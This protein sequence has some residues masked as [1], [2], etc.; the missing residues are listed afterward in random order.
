LTGV[1]LWVKKIPF[2]PSATGGSFSHCYKVKSTDGKEAF[3]KA[4]DYSRALRSGD[5]AAELQKLT[6]AYIFERDILEL[7]NNKGLDRVVRAIKSG[8]VT[9]S[10]GGS[11][12]VVQ[13]LIFE[14]ADCD[15]RSQLADATK[16]NLSWK[17]KCLHNIA[18]GLGQLHSIE[19][20]HQDVKP[21]NV[22]VFDNKISKIAD[23]GRAAHKRIVAPHDHY[24][25]AGDPSY[26]P[27]EGL[28][29]FIQ[30]DWIY[31]RMGCDCYL[32]GSMVTFF[33]TGFSATAL[34]LKNLDKQH[35]WLNWNGTFDQ[36]LPFLRESYRLVILECEASIP[37]EKLRIE[38]IKLIKEL[39]EPD[40]RIRGDK[41]QR[42]K[43]GSPFA[44]ERYI[45]RF[46]TLAYQSEAG[47]FA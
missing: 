13:Y 8:N 32:L 45:S 4:L 3:L 11:S 17:L 19:I 41:S 5:P 27:P 18:T 24:S 38:I 34:L 39:C 16:I 46:N 22:L 42:N 12:E 29:N 21:S 31:R 9:V 26:S 47:F 23:L 25:F 20:A 44:T 28:Y 37:N 10:C 1:G 14:K 35:H 2:P 40:P 30:P 43:F 6:A 36:V 7:C 15:V 33:F